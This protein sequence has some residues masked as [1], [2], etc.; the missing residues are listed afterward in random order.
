MAEDGRISGGSEVEGLEESKPSFKGAGSNDPDNQAPKKPE[1]NTLEHRL[2]ERLREEVRA[3]RDDILDK[4]E[5]RTREVTELEHALLDRVREHSEVSRS[6][7]LEKVDERARQR[8]GM[9]MQRLGLFA[10]VFI[11]CLSVGYQGLV[12]TI[13]SDIRGELDEEIKFA[14]KEI[15]DEGEELKSSIGADL[16]G[17]IRA[18]APGIVGGIIGDAAHPLTRQ[19]YDDIRGLTRALLA[20]IAGDQNDPTH[21]LLRDSLLGDLATGVPAGIDRNGDPGSGTPQGRR[22]QIER[23]ITVSRNIA[24]GDGYTRFEADEA[25]QLLREVMAHSSLDNPQVR[26]A[27]ERILSSIAGADD[28]RTIDDVLAILRGKHELAEFSPEM[29]LSLT[30]YYTQYV[31]SQEPGRMTDAIQAD[32]AQ[33]EEILAASNRAGIRD[34]YWSNRLILA[35]WQGM[36][37]AHTPR[38]TAAF[39]AALR[40]VLTAAAGRDQREAETAADAIFAVMLTA[41]P[42][43]WSRSQTG[44]VVAV[45]EV[46]GAAL[47]LGA[48]EIEAML[49]NDVFRRRLAERVAVVVPAIRKF[50]SD[51]SELIVRA[52]AMGLDIPDECG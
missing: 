44:N 4:V 35:T 20:D 3:S 25:V 43:A 32:L 33:A 14:L 48:E 8:E 36:T 46:A 19:L 37:P 34:S 49:G 13:K 50:G 18:Q 30:I 10:F 47:D 7:V 6:H 21:E 42:R 45:G 5:K 28:R 12:G 41:S 40:D 1:Q 39:E 29:L 38:R 9:T 52:C 2:L 17:Q 11:A 22:E 51:P 26:G 31:A 23:L 27:V 15:R 24:M 16:E